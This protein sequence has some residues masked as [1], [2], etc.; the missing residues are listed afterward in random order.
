M[1]L[2]SNLISVYI[3]YPSIGLRDLTPAPTCT[4]VTCVIPRLSTYVIVGYIYI[5]IEREREDP[6]SNPFNS[7]DTYWLP[8]YED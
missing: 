8:N 7:F 4:Y 1:K 5:Y 3:I 2:Y 6:V